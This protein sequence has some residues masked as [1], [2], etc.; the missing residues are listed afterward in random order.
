MLE[1]AVEASVP[2]F[3]GFPLFLEL[4]CGSKMPPYS[5]N[6]VSNACGAG[7]ANLNRQHPGNKKQEDCESVR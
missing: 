2:Y 5:G 7:I 3:Y 6:Y 1:R 4:L